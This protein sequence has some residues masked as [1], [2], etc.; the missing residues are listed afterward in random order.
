MFLIA[1]FYGSI[2]GVTLTAGIDLFRTVGLSGS[3]EAVSSS[4]GIEV[5]VLRS[6]LSSIVAVSDVS[7]INLTVYAFLILLPTDDNEAEI[8]T[9][10][11]TSFVTPER[12]AEILIKERKIMEV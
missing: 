6:L 9:D 12:E 2:S 5:D 10:I 4:S 11:G 3:V 8:I 1:R 7:A